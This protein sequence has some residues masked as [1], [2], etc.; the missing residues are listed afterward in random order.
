MERAPIIAIDVEVDKE[1]MAYSADI[2]HVNLTFKNCANATR[3]LYYFSFPGFS[4]PHKKNWGSLGPNETMTVNFSMRFITSYNSN[5]FDADSIIHFMQQYSAGKATLIGNSPRGLDNLLLA[6]PPGANLTN[7]SIK[8]INTSSYL[9]YWERFNDVVYVENNYKLALL[10]S[11]YAS[12]KN[13][14]LVIKGTPLDNATNF[15]GKNVVRV[16]NVFCPSGAVCNES[17]N[18]E[19]LQRKY[20][21]LTNTHKVILVNPQDLNSSINETFRTA[22]GGSS[23]QNLYMGAS[24]A[25]PILAAAKKELIIFYNHTIFD[26]EG[27]CTTTNIEPIIEDVRAKSIGI[28]NSLFPNTPME[29]L[30][31]TIIAAPNAIPD[32]SYY[33]CPEGPEQRHATDRTLLPGSKTGRIYSLTI[34]DVSSYIARSVFYNKLFYN[35][36]GY[37]SN[38]GFIVASVV[39]EGGIED[40]MDTSDTLEIKRLTSPYGYDTRCLFHGLGVRGSTACEG[41]SP[42]IKI[43]EEH[44]QQKQFIINYGHGRPDMWGGNLEV[45]DIPEL[46]LPYAHAFS[47]STAYFWSASD[48]PNRQDRF[49]ARLIRQGAIGYH[50]LVGVGSSDPSQC[51]RCI[52]HTAFVALGGLLHYQMTLGDLDLYMSRA[53]AGFSDEGFNFYTLLGDPTLKMNFRPVPVWTTAG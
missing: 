2:V 22:R 42:S 13:A 50:G 23:I 46:D 10:A 40:I 3:S 27:S 33:L 24:L 6:S 25:A 18:L 37:G 20:I 5:I 30:Y 19:S 21:S 35:K 17:Y 43:S 51:P 4:A 8:R 38:T 9:D 34:S 15:S 32:S 47:C 16:G 53:V 45:K 29:Y 48:M 12:L 26:K 1:E 41:L 31:L 49:G 7:S 36:Y 44:F 52:P 11:T 39:S 14:P 28:I